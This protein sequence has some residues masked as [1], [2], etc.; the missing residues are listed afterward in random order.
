MSASR[1]PPAAVRASSAPPAAAA[2]AGAPR[3]AAAGVGDDDAGAD[4]GAAGAAA[5][6]ALFALSVAMVVAVPW[7]E[8]DRVPDP[9]VWKEA[10]AHDVGALRPHDLVL[11]HPPWRDDVVKALRGV[12][13]LPPGVVIT[14]AL[15]PRHGDPLAPLVVVREAGGPPLPR[16][17]RGLVEERTRFEEGGV[18]IIRLAASASDDEVGVRDLSDDIAQAHVEVRMEPRPPPG[19]ALLPPAP[20]AGP[21]P[22]TAPGGLGGIKRGR[23]PPSLI[24]CPWDALQGRHVCPGL[25][26]WM[27]VGVEQLPIDGKRV[28]CTWAHP[29]TGGAV[30]VDFPHAHLL[31]HLKLEL[32]LTDGAADN[33]TAAPVSAALAVDGVPVATLDKPPGRRG[34][35]S[36]TVAVDGAPRDGSVELR[37]TTPHDGQRHTCFRLTT[38][39]AP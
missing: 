31:A 3:A 34:F 23:S 6:V 10:L 22:S 37:I 21:P 16:A 38:S 28:A 30:V 12:P 17:L 13:G 24:G 18:E 11:V 39:E 25:P 5:V 36:R 19:P 26:A 33:T 8:R 4:G 7:C 27:H 15:A 9:G 35:V 20:A 32:A 14:D 2:A 1:E 29:I